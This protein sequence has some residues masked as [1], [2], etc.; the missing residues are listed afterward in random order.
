VETI[1]A[2]TD[3]LGVNL[4]TRARILPDPE[5]GVG[6]RVAAPT[7]EVTPMGYEKAPRA[8]GDFVRFVSQ[9][10][11]RPPI[12]VTENGVCDNTEP[13]D[14]EVEDAGRIALLRGFLQGLAGA[15]EDGAADVRSYYLWSLLDNFEWAFGYSKR[16]GIV[17]VDYATLA[18][19]PKASAH[20]YSNVIRQNGFDTEG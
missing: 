11:G 15:I 2:P 14:G 1:A 12:H 19:T 20:W 8:L 3:F 6:F 18:R 16:F 10:Y 17:H 4:Y 7:L 9:E 5:R 13:T